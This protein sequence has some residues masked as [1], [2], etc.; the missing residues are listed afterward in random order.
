MGLQDNLTS[1]GFIV[2]VKQEKSQELVAT[3]I[4]DQTG[5]QHADVQEDD[6]DDSH[7]D[8]DHEDSDEDTDEDSIDQNE[9]T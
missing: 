7:S 6:D 3:S 5:N 2:K 8:S 1:F 9:S 4:E